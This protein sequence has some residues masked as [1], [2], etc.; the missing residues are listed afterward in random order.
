LYLATKYAAIFVDRSRPQ[1]V[2]LLES[3]TVGREVAS[4]RERHADL[5]GCFR[6]TGVTCGCSSG[7]SATG[8]KYEK[9]YK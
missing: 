3:Q 1:L 7:A 9:R 4:K 2:S 6:L 8:T 5:D